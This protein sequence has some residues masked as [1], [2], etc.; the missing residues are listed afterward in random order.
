MTVT[1]ISYT[2]ATASAATGLSERSI[3]DAIRRG[4]LIAHYVTDRPSILAGDLAAW[5][6]SGP[7]EKRRSA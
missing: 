7:T 3:A 2:L 1:T 4:D 5:I 6:E